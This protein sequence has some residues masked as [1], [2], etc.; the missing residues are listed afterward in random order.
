M[1]T[2]YLTCYPIEAKKDNL[3]ARL[4]GVAGIPPCLNTSLNGLDKLS[5]TFTHHRDHFLTIWWI[6]I[7]ETRKTILL[8]SA[9][10]WDIKLF[11]SRYSHAKSRRDSRQHTYTCRYRCIS[12]LHIRQKL[13]I[14]SKWCFMPIYVVAEKYW[15]N[16][17]RYYAHLSSPGSAFS[18]YGR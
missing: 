5:S 16:A 6:G 8:Y 17:Y 18:Y 9:L 15:K 14:R 2:N 3:L 1:R 11:Y 4:S 7:S 12:R 10:L 13:T